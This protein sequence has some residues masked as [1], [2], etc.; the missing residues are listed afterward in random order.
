MLPKE[1]TL[2]MR[3]GFPLSCA[4]F[5]KKNALGTLQIVHGLKGHKERFYEFAA[6]MQAAGFT[7]ILSDLRGHGA[8]VNEDWPLGHMEGWK[9][10]TEDLAEIRRFALEKYGGPFFLFGHSFGSVLLR[11]S[12]PDFDAQ[13]AKLI[14]AGPLP[15]AFW[16]KAILLPLGLIKR[17]QGSKVSF[18]PLRKMGGQKDLSWV[19][20]DPAVLAALK[21]DPLSNGILSNGGY[22]TFCDSLRALSD[23]LPAPAQHPALPILFIAGGKD[24]KTGGEKGLARSSALLERAG[25]GNI[26]LSVYPQL[27]HET[28]NSL[29]KE[30]VWADIAAFL[31]ES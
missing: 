8:S 29:D 1:F 24:P 26:R 3:D 27:A 18:P 7:V 11:L 17:L 25:Y 21:K 28:I 14:L 9:I 23:K 31:K 30:K 4:V 16:T 15:Y 20:A 22:Y 2:Q 6:A 13:T 19:N 5:E 10:L 12:L